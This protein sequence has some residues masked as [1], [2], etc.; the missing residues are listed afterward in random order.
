M[1]PW[2]D[3]CHQVSTKGSLPMEI[4]LVMNGSQGRLHIQY[5]KITV[6]FDSQVFRTLRSNPTDA[7]DPHVLHYHAKHH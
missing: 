3:C 7:A 4:S 2:N 6:Q 5:I 1:R